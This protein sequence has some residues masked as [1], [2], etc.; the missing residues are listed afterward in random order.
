MGP[1]SDRRT[2]LWTPHMALGLTVMNFM[3]PLL[4]H[5]LSRCHLILTRREDF[6]DE[7][8]EAFMFR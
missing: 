1:V 4:T 5:N 8:A 3:A 6:M 2:R 7:K